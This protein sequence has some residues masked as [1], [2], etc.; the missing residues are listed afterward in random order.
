M[1]RMSIVA[2]AFQNFTSLE[3]LDLGLNK[4]S[5]INENAF[6]GLSNL[7]DLRLNSNCLATINKNMFN[8]LNSLENLNL[9]VN[10]I[11]AKS[12]S[13]S[14]VTSSVCDSKE[15]QS[16][17]ETNDNS[18]TALENMKELTLNENPIV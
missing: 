13:D 16:I 7:K 1:N 8:G 11:T 2:N 12:G 14:A 3:V 4:I 6:V 10:P 18:V 9:S 15:Y 17:S 5:A